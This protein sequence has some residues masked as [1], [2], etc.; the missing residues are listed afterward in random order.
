[1]TLVNIF[2]VAFFFEAVIKA[3]HMNDSRRSYQCIK[4]LVTLATEC[5]AA[6]EYLLQTA[7]K[8]Q[9]AVN[10]LSRKVDQ[11]IYFYVNI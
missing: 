8:W 1:M 10:W 9:W 4:F 5:S 11:Y 2:I 6:K 7:S 3:H